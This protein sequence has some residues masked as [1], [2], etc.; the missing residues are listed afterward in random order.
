MHTTPRG[1]M[2]WTSWHG[3]AMGV[4]RAGELSDREVVP[5]GVMVH[6][7]SVNLFLRLGIIVSSLSFVD[8]V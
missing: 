3:C 7:F 1:T 4:R 6:G 5:G 2:V 8:R